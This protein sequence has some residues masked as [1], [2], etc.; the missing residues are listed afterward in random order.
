MDVFIVVDGVVQNIAVADSMEHAAALFAPAQ[1]YERT[2]DNSHLNP[3]DT[4]VAPD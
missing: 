3:G 1:V 4:Y 2:S